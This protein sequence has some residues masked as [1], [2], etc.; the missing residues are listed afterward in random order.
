LQQT[1]ECKEGKPFLALKRAFPS[2][3][4]SLSSNGRKALLEFNNNLH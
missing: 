3:E 4:E 2:Y 1:K